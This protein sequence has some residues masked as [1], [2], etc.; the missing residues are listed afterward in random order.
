MAQVIIRR[1][2][3]SEEVI[4]EVGNNFN[5]LFDI[6]FTEDYFFLECYGKEEIVNILGDSGFEAS[7]ENIKTVFAELKESGDCNVL[8][9]SED[10][11]ENIH[12]IIRGAITNVEDTLTKKAPNKVKKNEDYER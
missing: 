9:C 10:S 7:D 4:R 6:V 8:D 11:S 12:T 1:D 3:G 2:D 5:K